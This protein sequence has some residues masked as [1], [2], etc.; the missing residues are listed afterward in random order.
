MILAGR[1]KM[2]RAKA[3]GLSAQMSG[4]VQAGFLSQLRGAVA[5]PLFFASRDYAKWVFFGLMALCTLLVI[6]TDERFLLTPSDPE[7]RHIEPFKW[8]L[9]VHGPFGALALTL[10][11]LQF[12]DTLRRI[13]PNLHRWTGRIYITAVVIASCVS[14][15]IGPRFERPSIQIEQYFQGGLW[16]ITTLTALVCILYRNIAAHKL[17]MMRSYGFC[18]VFVLSRVPD[19]IPG[20]KWTSQSISDTLWGLVVAALVAPDLILTARDFWRRRTR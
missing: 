17:W 18:L 1:K 10:G 8:W 11:P 14:L 20:F 12:S 15:Y 16:L 4:S 5:G 13:R 3:S 6:W 7:W 9:L 19:A 2:T